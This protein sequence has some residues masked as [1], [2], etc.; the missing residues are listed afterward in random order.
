MSADRKQLATAEELAALEFQPLDAESAGKM[1]DDFSA[2][3]LGGRVRRARRRAAPCLRADDR[4]KGENRRND[5]V[6]GKE[7]FR[8]GPR[9][10]R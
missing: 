6:H 8:R 7:L 9:P 5:R 3:P 2:E 4:D 10:D 1:Y